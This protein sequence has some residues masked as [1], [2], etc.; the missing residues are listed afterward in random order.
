[1]ATKQ[2][3]PAETE[4]QTGTALAAQT[5]STAVANPEDYAAYA[6]AGFENQTTDDYAI[7]FLS[8]LQ[9]LSP[10]CT[11]NPNVFRQGMLLNTVTG[12]LFEGNKGL[13]FIPA[14]TQHLYVEW[15]PRE[16]GGGFVAVH[17]PASEVVK[18]AQAASTEYGTYL[19]PPHTPK[20]SN[21]LIETFYVYGVAVD[22]DGSSIEAV[23][24]FTSAKIKKYKAW[25][26]KAK[27]IQ[28]A[29]PDGRRI[30]APLFAHRYRLKTILEKNPKGTFFNFDISFDGEN[31]MACRLPPSSDLF[32]QAV[33]VKQLIEQGKAR[34]AHETQTPGS[35]GD[36]GSGGSSAGAGGAPAGSK[37]V[38]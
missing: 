24:P 6:G 20:E 12:E 29:L 14:T 7:P 3:K 18:I 33:N 27:T 5:T 1:M 23:L 36:D 16:K 2:P 38:F 19:M 8:I 26:T 10:Q 35:G 21:E 17:D 11:E 9:A 37:P 22:D 34:A 13:A 32:Q 15:K 30:P 28:I 4:A 31:A 25:M